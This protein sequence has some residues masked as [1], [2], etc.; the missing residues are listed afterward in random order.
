MV[1]E[2]GCG[3]GVHGSVVDL[4]A[5][6]AGLGRIDVHG[7]ESWRRCAGLTLRGPIGELFGVCCRYSSCPVCAE[8]PGQPS[9]RRRRVCDGMPASVVGR[10]LEAWSDS[11]VS[12][13]TGALQTR[14]VSNSADRSVVGGR[15]MSGRKHSQAGIPQID[16][17]LAC[18]EPDGDRTLTATPAVSTTS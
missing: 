4:V 3:D 14:D 11:H 7:S 5:A 9:A 2:G 6:P 13:C 10:E 8:S 15:P 16:F 12:R 18:H 1:L 17:D